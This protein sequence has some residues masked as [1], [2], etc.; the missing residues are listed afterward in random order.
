[1]MQKTKTYGVGN[2]R[3][4]LIELP[5]L[6]DQIV[7]GKRFYQAQEMATNWYGIRL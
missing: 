3:Q 4:K 5:N 1:M 2:F 7:N 6:K